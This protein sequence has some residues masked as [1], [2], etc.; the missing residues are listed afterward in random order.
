LRGGGTDIIAFADSD[1]TVWVPDADLTTD[2]KFCVI[3]LDAAGS[4]RSV[5]LF[6]GT[7]VD[8]DGK[9]YVSDNSD[10]ISRI[11]VVK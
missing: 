3:R 5:Y 7:Y 1:P 8:F 6:R 2:A 9:R 10:G 4:V 11:I